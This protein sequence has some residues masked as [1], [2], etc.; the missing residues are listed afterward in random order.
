M[1]SLWGRSHCHFDS[2]RH[3][4]GSHTALSC[5]PFLH[6][7]SMR[8]SVSSMSYL[9]I[10]PASWLDDAVAS[11]GTLTPLPSPV[12]RF[13]SDNGDAGSHVARDISAE[14]DAADELSHSEETP[15]GTASPCPTSGLGTTAPV[16]TGSATGVP[17][18]DEHVFRSK[19][20]SQLSAASSTVLLTFRNR[21]GIS[22]GLVLHLPH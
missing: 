8:S 4:Y 3:L 1:K 22:L 14:L 9:I 13:C 19:M 6:A 20:F 18:C 16:A 7:D 2:S 5:D 17:R 11:G 12:A 15:R 21:R 10:E